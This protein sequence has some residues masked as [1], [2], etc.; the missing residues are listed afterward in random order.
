MSRTYRSPAA[1]QESHRRMRHLPVHRSA[2]DLARG[3]E[4]A[5][6]E[7]ALPVGRTRPHRVVGVNRERARANPDN[8]PNTW[9]DL[10]IAAARE[11]LRNP[12]VPGAV[13]RRERIRVDDEPA[14]GL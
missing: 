10:P 8:Q 4:E 12:R 14:P 13:R 6:A 2:E 3:V 1:A 9:S 11:A 7:P 5:M